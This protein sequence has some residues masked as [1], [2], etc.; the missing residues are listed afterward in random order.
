[1]PRL[2]YL[3]LALLEAAW[4]IAL[5]SNGIRQPQWYAIPGGLYFVGIGWL[6]RRRARARAQPGEGGTGLRASLRLASLIEGFGLALLLLTA[7]VQSLGTTDGFPYFVLLLVEA[8]LAIWWG[9]AWRIKLPFFVGLGASVVNVIAQ[10]IVLVNVYDINRFLVIFGAGIL[11]VTLA[12]FV[13]RQRAR[14]LLTA[15]RWLEALE[16][17]E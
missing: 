1:L 16:L 4:M 9:A 10:I 12:V 17:W 7:F 6:E 3:G 8:L 2:G 15:Q 5:A 13:E 14:I 11:L